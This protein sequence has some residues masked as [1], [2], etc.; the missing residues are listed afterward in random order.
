MVGLLHDSKPFL[1]LII[2]L[3]E[4]LA[5]FPPLVD[6][7]LVLPLHELDFVEDVD[8]VHLFDS[9][10]Y[11]L[12]IVPIYPHRFEFYLFFLSFAK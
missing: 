4:F 12:G 7:R 2:I 6:F 9:L 3:E 8:V 1:G 10:C 11:F 5:G